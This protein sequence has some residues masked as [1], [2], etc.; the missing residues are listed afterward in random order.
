MD[1][2]GG[3]NTN[4]HL[5]V[6]LFP[7]VYGLGLNRCCQDGFSTIY[8]RIYTEE[9]GITSQPS[10]GHPPANGYTILKH[11]GRLK[12]LEG[13]L[14]N[15][16]CL[17]SCPR[18]LGLWVFSPT[19]GFESLSNLY[20]KEGSAV[21]KKILIDTTTLKVSATGSVASQDLMRSLSSEAQ[22]GQQRQQQGQPA[23]RRPDV[24]GGS[25]AIYAS[26]ISAV[27]GA[28]S[29]HLIRS[30][31]A[32]PLGSRTLFTALESVGYES[33]R[34]DNDSPFSRSCL[35]TLNAQ[36]NPSG[37]LTISTQTIVQEGLSRLCSPHDDVADLLR[38]QPGTDLWICPNGTVA[39]LVTANIESPT[40]PSPGFIVPADAA[41][42]K[43]QWKSDVT[44]WLSNFG[45]YIDS[46]DEEP[47][48]E[49]EV[50][51]PFFARLAGEAW[52]QGEESQIPL[53]L[54][55]MLWP[56]RFCFRRTGSQLQRHSNRDSWPESFV[57]DPL[58]FAERWPSE[59]DAILANQQTQSVPVLEKPQSKDQDMT[60]SKVENVEGF[61]SLAR[62]A[63]YPDLPPA[64]LVYPTPPDGAAA[65]G[66]H[67]INQAEN[68]PDDADSNNLSPAGPMD[69][70]NNP[71]AR[72]SPDIGIGTG[73]YDASDDEDLFGEMKERDFG[74]RGITDADFSFFDDPEL[75]DMDDV[76]T[77]RL[78]E[79]E[80]PVLV[81][82]KP[83]ESVIGNTELDVTATIDAPDISEE[84][85]E[86]KPVEAKQDDAEPP[87]EPMGSPASRASSSDS[88]SPAIISPPLSPVEVKKILF[89]GARKD[90]PEK[91]NDSRAQQGHYHPVTFEKKIGDWDHK[92]GAAGKF[93]FSSDS[94]AKGSDSSPSAI[95][96]IGLPHR[97]RSGGSIARAS[98]ATKTASPAV[99][100]DDNQS[101][102]DSESESSDYSDDMVSEHAQ[103]AP[104]LV[105]LKRKRVASDSDL[106]SAASP[107]K[108]A[109]ASDGS[110][111]SKVDNCAFLG[112]FL[113]NFS[114]W[115]FIGYFSTFLVQQLPVLVRKED[116]IPIAQ[117]LVDQI[118]QSSLNHTLGGHI[119]LFD[120]ESESFTWRTYLE[121]VSFLGVPAKLDLKAYTSLQE[122][123]AVAAS[124]Q[125]SNLSLKDPIVKIPAPHVRIRRGKEYL[126][127]LPPAIS[128]WETFDL[129]PAHG[130]KDIS[131][132]CIHPHAAAK[133]ADVFL[134]RSGLH[135]QSCN[136]GSHSRGDKS[137][138]FENGLKS[139]GS[140]SSN[141]ASMMQSL[142]GICEELGMSDCYSPSMDNCVVYIINPFPHAT[143]LA[144]I[145]AAFWHLLQQMLADTDRQQGQP[146]NEVVLQIIPMDFVTSGDSMVV[147]TQTEFMNLSLEVYSRCRPKETGLSPLLCAPAILL[148]H[149][150]PKAINFRLASDKASPLQDGR[151]LHIACSKS[152]D[153]RWLSVAWSDEIGSLQ[154][155]MSYCLRYRNRGATRA[156]ADIRNEIWATTRHI[157]EKFQARW[158]VILANSEPIDPDEVEAWNTLAEQQNKLRPG[159][160]E[161]TLITV[162]TTPDLILEP[163]PTQITTNVL[164]G[165]LSS[166]PVS[167][168][169][170]SVSVASP[171][172]SANAPTPT[173]PTFEPDS[174]VVLTDLS[175]ESWAVILSH[176]LNSSPHITEL[177]SALA[178]GYLLRRK[179]T[180]DGDG[181]HAMTVNLIHSQRPASSHEP[182]LRE[183]LGM[184]RD[185]AS[186]ARARGMRS[187]QGNTLPWHIA[188]A[189]RAQ[190]LLS[191]VF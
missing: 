57:D 66:M 126:E 108:S 142:K 171:E 169:N 162:T 134:N 65:I 41:V 154:A 47:W 87:D 5:I 187:V 58:N 135:Y 84:A 63:Q 122:S 85:V 67:T 170:P 168:P 159:F 25:T 109:G 120:Q 70:K 190:E 182:L 160:I 18:R 176:R 6:S 156:V 138:A 175:D 141:Y 110:A 97:G 74:S 139:W 44:Q 180:T 22:A 173:E 32:L 114:D 149:S 127:A 113:A 1:F 2:P 93:W 148:A 145:C 17:V 111:N 88:A 4:V 129:E 51:E 161:L 155:C 91:S 177:R 38:A 60:S 27:A 12:D 118:T 99:L 150:L 71:N 35:T 42:K 76:P 49:I 107:A 11:L 39:R 7:Q 40:A 178:S 95:P 19:P 188:T 69:P 167:T 64:N 55:R 43:T 130:P 133:A 68:F 30:H 174:D 115:N 186:L 36:L 185:L 96:T 28:I 15:L 158:K 137:M 98:L 86:V 75:D 144:D 183:I 163:T 14:R 16:N 132:Y 80:P 89:S 164:I 13:K 116:Q 112:N 184:Y 191:Y 72:L 83:Q 54:K 143:A 128:F 105:S 33:P 53:P 24:Y 103:V 50:W 78:E 104:T 56:A 45:L 124:Q 9:S 147:P 90:D 48:V 121:E 46:V 92:Y 153:Q 100:D 140:G 31:G 106:Q 62:M 81:E 59:V 23:P 166:T 152:P 21:S 119:G 157:M 172:Q 101:S 117:L 73:H 181:V 165:Q 29:L 94:L 34:V 131:S 151:S 8:W 3:A 10:E 79:P 179:G 82:E 102:L 125:P 136:L 123:S 52:R 77:A 146:I 26:F 61:E 37:I 189:L 20:V